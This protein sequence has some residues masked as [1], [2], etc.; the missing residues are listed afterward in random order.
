MAPQ[1][2]RQR[3][4]VAAMRTP[5]EPL[6]KPIFMVEQRSF[7]PPVTCAELN[8]NVPAR[9]RNMAMAVRAAGGHVSAPGFTA[10]QAELIVMICKGHHLAASVVMPEHPRQAALAEKL[11]SLLAPRMPALRTGFVRAP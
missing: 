10:W 11:R 2:D 6:F 9:E 4:A 3:L 1:V 5:S 7:A 8:E